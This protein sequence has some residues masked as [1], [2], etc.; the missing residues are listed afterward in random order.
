ME[1]LE[2]VIDVQAT[3]VRELRGEWHRQLHLEWELLR[4][5]VTPI[6]KFSRAEVGRNPDLAALTPSSRHLEGRKLV[7]FAR[8]MMTVAADHAKLF[9]EEYNAVFLRQAR[10]AVDAVAE[11]MDRHANLKVQR[12]GATAGLAGLIT[13]G[14]NLLLQLDAAVEHHFDREARFYLEWKIAIRVGTP[15][16][17]KKRAT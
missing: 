10:A 2:A 16:I 12:A 11:S 1:A 9:S 7:N 14:R 13:K 5:F 8:S 6:A 17:R 3:R 4:G 15:P